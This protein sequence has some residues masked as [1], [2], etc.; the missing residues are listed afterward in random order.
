MVGFVLKLL[1]RKVIYDAH[2][3]TPLQI[4]YQHW[5]PRLLRRPYAAF[6]YIIEKLAG[7]LFD[8]IIVA[9]P[10]LQKYY[11]EKKLTSFVAESSLVPRPAAAI[12]ALFGNKFSFL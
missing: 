6:Y 5:I 2:E 9:E 1:G 10:V 12:T 7:W 3:D 11:P 4:R 8:A